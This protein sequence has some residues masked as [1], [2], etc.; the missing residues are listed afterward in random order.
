MARP[1]WQHIRILSF[2]TPCLLILCA[3]QLEPRYFEGKKKLDWLVYMSVGGSEESLKMMDFAIS[4]LYWHQEN[5]DIQTIVLIDP[6]LLSGLVEPHNRPSHVDFVPWESLIPTNSIRKRDKKVVSSMRKLEIFNAYPLIHQF[7][8]VLY[9]DIDMVIVNS[10]K[11][12]Y[13][14]VTSDAKKLHVV[15]ESPVSLEPYKNIFYSNLDYTDVEK[16][17][18][19]TRPGFSAGL[20]AFVPSKEME[21]HFDKVLQLVYEHKSEIHEFYEQTH[22]NKYFGLNS[23]VNESLSQYYTS[24]QEYNKTGTRVVLAHFPGANQE[25]DLKYQRMKHFWKSFIDCI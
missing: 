10:L 14:T 1:S 16:K 9:L 8:S 22:M 13:K 3:L 7:K 4:T 23:I 19:S 24:Q 5:T 17:I 12:L 20:F 6:K 25:L 18:M 21:I 2:L 11:P 15:M